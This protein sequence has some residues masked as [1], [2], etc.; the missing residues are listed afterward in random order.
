[1]VTSIFSLIVFF[2]V[3]V[4]LFFSFFDPFV[5]FRFLVVD[6]FFVFFV[7]LMFFFSFSYFFCWGNL[8]YF[9]GC[10]L[11][12]SNSPWFVDLC[13][14]SFGYRVC[15]SFRFSECDAK[16]VDVEVNVLVTTCESTAISNMC[17]TVY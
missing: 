3:E 1:M 7:F 6:L 17:T 12:S 13:S 9:F 4:Y 14:Y 11:I 16:D 8:G 2:N 10:D 5:F 15:F